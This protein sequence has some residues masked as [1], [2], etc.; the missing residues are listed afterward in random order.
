LRNPWG[1]LSWLL[2]L[3][4]WAVG[5][6]TDISIAEP[7]SVVLA[8]LGVLFRIVSDLRTRKKG[9]APESSERQ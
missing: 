3:L 8:A 6:S 4:A 2:L 7:I 9:A 5:I 1:D